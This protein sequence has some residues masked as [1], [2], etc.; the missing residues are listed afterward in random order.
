MWHD[1]FTCTCLLIICDTSQFPFNHHHHHHY[2]PAHTPAD[3]DFD[4]KD[5]TENNDNDDR[6]GRWRWQWWWCPLPTN[7]MTTKL[8]MWHIQACHIN[9]DFPDNEC[10]WLQDP[11]TTP[12]PHHHHH[13]QL[14]MTIPHPWTMTTHRRQ[15][16]MDDDCPWKM[17]TPMTMRTPMMMKTPHGQRRPPMN[18]DHHGPIP[19]LWTTTTHRWTDDKDHLW[20]MTPQDKQQWLPTHECEHLQITTTP[21][22][23]PYRR[24]APTDT[25][26]PHWWWWLPM[27]ACGQWAP[28]DRDSAP[29]PMNREWGH[30]WW[31]AMSAHP[32]PVCPPL[33]VCLPPS[34][35]P[36][37]V[38]PP[39]SLS[40]PLVCLSPLFVS[41]YVPFLSF[42]S[43][44]LSLSPLSVC[45]PPYKVQ[46]SKVIFIILNILEFYVFIYECCK[47][48]IC[49]GELSTV[50]EFTASA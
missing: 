34:L 11:T 32:L 17:K 38:C 44:C 33:P 43:S 39:P 40:V 15:P 21:K 22:Q 28:M 41:L 47:D 6:C 42:P 2:T 19:H 8:L 1:A 25:T 10:P 36:L 9:S 14:T 30:Q 29:P 13:P 26:T 23:W 5:N 27:C 50:S 35:S 49:G 4:D 46:S 3:N 48:E 18:N 16:P 7:C 24:Q 12:P 45:L 20:T 31:T 37:P